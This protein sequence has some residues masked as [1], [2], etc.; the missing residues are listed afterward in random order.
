MSGKCQSFVRH[1]LVLNTNNN[2]NNELKIEDVSV[3]GLGSL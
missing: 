1:P 2:K 3:T